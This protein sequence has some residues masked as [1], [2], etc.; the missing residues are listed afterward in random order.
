MLVAEM[1]DVQLPSHKL[2]LC[3]QVYRNFSTETKSAKGF[4]PD[5]STGKAAGVHLLVSA[6]RHNA[7]RMT[8]AV[9]PLFVA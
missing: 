6:G 3:L 7:S 8:A 2:Y 4:Y 9:D 1:F 5:C